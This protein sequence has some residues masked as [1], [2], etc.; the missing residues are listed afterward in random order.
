MTKDNSLLGKFDLTGLPAMPRGVPQVEVTFDVDAN[1]IL[2]VSAVEKSTGKENKIRITNDKGRLSKDEVDRMVREAEK[3]RREDEAAKDCVEARNALEHLCYQ[4][5]STLDE[6]K[7][8]VPEP[9][10]KR[11]RSKLDDTVKWLDTNG[12][13]ASKHDLDAKKRELEQ[14]AQP[15]FQKAAGNGS[16]GK[17]S[18]GGGRSGNP[19]EAPEVQEVD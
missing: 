16:S 5:K 18:P 11:L 14:L 3:Y 6:G 15:I 7:L 13:H 12:L 9:D 2:N 1:G 4:F 17:A 8:A 19:A 10:A